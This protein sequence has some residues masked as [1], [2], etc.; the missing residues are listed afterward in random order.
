M[1]VCKL[2]LDD[3]SPNQKIEKSS[4]R[5]EKGNCRC[6]V[7]KRDRLHGLLGQSDRVY[8]LNSRSPLPS[9][10]RTP[11]GQLAFA[12]R[13]FSLAPK[14]AIARLPKIVDGSGTAVLE[15]RPR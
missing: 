9:L 5:C 15:A 1:L 13:C 3:R 11:N 4:M 7:I 12:L 10:S 6:L 8:S 2:K 14:A